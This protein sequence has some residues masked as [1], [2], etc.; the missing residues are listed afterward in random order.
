MNLSHLFFLLLSLGTACN[1]GSE[2]K[3][4]VDADGDGVSDA[5]DAFPTDSQEWL[6]HNRWSIEGEHKS[7]NMRGCQTLASNLA[8]KCRRNLNL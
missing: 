5:N 2:V 4:D 3:E 1:S 8:P 7:Q 6:N